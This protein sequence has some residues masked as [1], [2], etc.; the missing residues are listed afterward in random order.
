MRLV[1]AAAIA[2]LLSLGAPFGAGAQPAMPEFRYLAAP[3]T[4]FY[5]SDP[6]AMLDTD[7]DG[8]VRACTATEACAGFTFDARS[9]GCFPSAAMTART[10]YAG[11]L[12]AEKITA[13][14]A[15]I[16]AAEGRA[17][18]LG[19]LAPEDITGARDQARLIGVSE[20]GGVFA[21]L[22]AE[23]ARSDAAAP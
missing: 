5:G 4:D 9:S 13:D 12:S 11:A 17:S 2:I 21:A 14:P 8:C 22:A 6:D 3:D 10:P 19:F 15:A 18:A 1:P 20:A 16:E 7:L 23:I